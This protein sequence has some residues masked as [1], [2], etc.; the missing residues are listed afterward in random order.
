MECE[1]CWILIDEY[2]INRAIAIF[3]EKPTMSDF[4]K[5]IEIGEINGNEAKDLLDRNF[6]KYFR[7]M[8]VKFGESIPY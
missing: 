8:K 6:C 2:E 5:L 7:L 3:K 4:N 1:T